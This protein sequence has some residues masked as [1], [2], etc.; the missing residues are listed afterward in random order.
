MHDS[1]NSNG[2]KGVRHKAFSRGPE[3]SISDPSD[4][5]CIVGSSMPNAMSHSSDLLTSGSA[6]VLKART[7]G[8]GD[9]VPRSK[10]A[11]DS[12]IQSTAV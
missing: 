8:H 12:S 6:H 1:R 11:G 10:K 3:S 7:R 5:W 9:V 2:R 4:D